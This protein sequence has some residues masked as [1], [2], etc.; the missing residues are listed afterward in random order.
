[1]GKSKHKR[2]SIREP[3]LSENS[4]SARK[5]AKQDV[6]HRMVVT[7][8]EIKIRGDVYI[9]LEKIID[10]AIAVSLCMTEDSLK[11]ASRRLKQ[12]MSNNK[13]LDKEEAG[14][15]VN[16]YGRRANLVGVPICLRALSFTLPI[17]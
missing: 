16:I 3:Q 14:V 1:M 9:N 5:R 4:R 2:K 15:V 11:C 8:L 6:V 10:D 17:L 13:L 7:S 12:K